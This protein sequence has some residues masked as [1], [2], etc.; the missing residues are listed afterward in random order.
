MRWVRPRPSQELKFEQRPFSPFEVWGPEGL[1]HHEMYSDVPTWPRFG[2]SIAR[3]TAKTLTQFSAMRRF[4][5]GRRD[6]RTDGLTNMLFWT[7]LH[8][9]PFGAIIFV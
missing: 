9:S 6:G 2:I 4:R 3:E 5:Y 8:N 1:P 7:P